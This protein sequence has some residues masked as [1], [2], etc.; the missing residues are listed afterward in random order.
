MFLEQAVDDINKKLESLDSESNIVLWG[1]GENAVR[2]FQ[3]T[4]LMTFGQLHIVDKKLFEHIFFG[5]MVRKPEDILWKTID[6]V[7][8]SVFVG[9]DEIRV[10][11]AEKYE[12]K[13]RVISINENLAVPFYNLSKKRDFVLDNDTISIL[14]KNGRYRNIHEGERVF[15]LCTGP[16]ISKMELA[17]LKDEKTIAVSGFF[18]HK[19]CQTISP[20][21]YC[22]PTFEKFLGFGL[23]TEYLRKIQE[24]TLKTQYFFS[25]YEKQIVDKMREYDNRCV[26]Y[27][28]FMSTPD[29]EKFNIDLTNP[30]PSP[31][32]VSIMALE[33]ALYMGFKTIYLLGTEHDSLLTGRY[34]HF[35]DYSESIVSQSNPD[36]NAQGK[37]K[38]SF[39]F[40]LAAIYNLWKQYKK[41]KQIAERNGAKIYNATKG[42]ILD[43]FERVDFDTLF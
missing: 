31:Q 21:Y 40:E 4:N 35:Y 33:I 3:Y 29:F 8:I 41:I 38:T 13:G 16:S 26:N 39:N 30:A 18:L 42:G 36:E 1:A 9:V 5:K 23:A 15:I 14:Q 11:L 6:A 24:S 32:S 12:F 2:L 20:D 19:D 10:E 7:I 17:K 27:V 28:A 25:I 43:V 34:T 37:C 22:L